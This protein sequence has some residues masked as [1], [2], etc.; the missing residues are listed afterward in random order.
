MV[1]KAF[2]DQD[3]FDQIHDFTVKFEAAANKS[4]SPKRE[5]PSE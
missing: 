1:A 3:L 4:Y 5:K 2:G